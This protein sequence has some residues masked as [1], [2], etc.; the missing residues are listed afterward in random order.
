[1]SKR[2]FG[3]ENLEV[4]NKLL[5]KFI[6]GNEV[7]TSNE[8]YLLIG[9][10]LPSP[11]TLSSFITGLSASVRNG[12]IP[13]Y[14]SGYRGHGTNSGYRKVL[15]QKTVSP[16]KTSNGYN[17]SFSKEQLPIV[18]EMIVSNFAKDTYKSGIELYKLIE[19]LFSN[20]ITEARFRSCLCGSIKQG[21]LNL[22]NV[23]GLGYKLTFPKKDKTIS[24]TKLL[25]QT[26]EQEIINP[27]ENCS[28]GFGIENRKIVQKIMDECLT[29]TEGKTGTELYKIIAPHLLN[30]VKKLSFTAALS[31]SVKCGFLTG[32]ISSGHRGSNS[33]G[34]RKLAEN[35]KAV[36]KPY[37]SRQYDYYNKGFSEQNL[38]IVKKLVD[39]HVVSDA[40][41][42]VKE[43]YDLIIPHLTKSIGQKCLS[44]S[45]FKNFFRHAFK[46]G[47][48]K[49][50]IMV[51]GLGFR[52][53]SAKEL[54]NPKPKDMI[55]KSEPIRRAMKAPEQVQEVPFISH[56]REMGS[57]SSVSEFE[58]KLFQINSMASHLNFA[59]TEL[60]EEVR[61]KSKG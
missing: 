16:K 23:K 54:L 46:N 2:G 55:P 15:N 11:V 9:P 4:V 8:L 60:F 31:L 34:F 17:H 26:K 22:I 12:D 58:E 28:G 42:R 21:L 13:G 47:Y 41:I 25:P 20:P 10:L 14:I 32:F 7:K 59:I 57:F 51:N 48:F 43:L 52:K 53:K 35:E 37:V 27:N 6:L 19:P 44:N 33:S 61:Q 1:M 30:P 24:E 39:R 49:N 40:F 18:Q 56:K 50:V 36:L 38:E 29:T 5:P 45:Q 3:K